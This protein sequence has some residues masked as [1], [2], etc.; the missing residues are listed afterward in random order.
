MK[1]QIAVRRALVMFLACYPVTFALQAVQSQ[2]GPPQAAPSLTDT[3]R[4]NV[5]EYIDLLRVD[6]QAQKAEIMGAMMGLDVNQSA[7]FWPIYSEYDAELT[8]L[9]NLTAGNIQDYARNYYQM[10]DAKADELAQNAFN[11]RRQRSELVAKY[12]GRVKDSLGG[13]EAMRFLQIEGQLLAI[14]DLQTASALPGPIEGQAQAA[15]TEV[16]TQAAPTRVTVPA[17]T[18]I[19]IRMVNSVDSRTQQ[20]GYRFTA[21]LE[22]NLQVGDVVVAPRGTTVYGRLAKAKSAGN[23]SGG[24]QLTLELTDIVINDTA[25]PLLTSTYQVASQGQ[26]NKT[27]GRIV[28]GAG[29]GALIGGLAGGGKGAAIGAGAGAAAGTTLSAGTKGKQV[30]VPSESL[31]EFRLQQPVS[32]PVA[33]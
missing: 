33:R 11:Y 16:Q 8:K 6:V 20:V 27:A 31:L 29:L 10:T 3:Q 9:S 24:A 2:S 13:V 14:I 25:H 4:N 17:G 7:K 15:P 1:K 21:N 32:L 18:R 30:S 22:T 5:L 19:L 26:G 23:M 12:Y 28:G